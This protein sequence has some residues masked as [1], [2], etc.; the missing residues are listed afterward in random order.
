MLQNK[1]QN[2]NSIQS[3]TASA[4]CQFFPQVEAKN[5]KLSTSYPQKNIF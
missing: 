2:K 1:K 5:L 3:Q 4:T